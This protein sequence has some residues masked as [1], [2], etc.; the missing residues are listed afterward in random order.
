MSSYE[1][2]MDYIHK[3]SNTQFYQDLI[4]AKKVMQINGKPMSRGEWNLIVSNR[5]LTGWVK[6]GMKPHK[7][8]KVTDVKRYFGIQGSGQKLLDRFLELKS[9]VDTIRKEKKEK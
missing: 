8:W 1:K 5:D 9:H 7:G 3:K 2:A 6:R 4:D